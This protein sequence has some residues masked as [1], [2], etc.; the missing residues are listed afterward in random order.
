M[1]RH[2]TALEHCG[3]KECIRILLMSW[4]LG[5]KETGRVCISYLSLA[6]TKWLIRSRL[7]GGRVSFRPTLS[8]YIVQY[9]GGGGVGDGG[10][11]RR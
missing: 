1:V 6:M 11:D 8:S 2:P 5:S 3:L 10:R 4:R 7:R 9:G